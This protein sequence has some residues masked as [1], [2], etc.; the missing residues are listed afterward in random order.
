M[1][2]WLREARIEQGLTA[3]QVSK[4][5]GVSESYYS[6]IENGLRQTPM[7]ITLA[8]KIGSVLNLPLTYLANCEVGEPQRL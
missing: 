4:E 8:V 5:L 6:M 7:D 2:S 3:A 1:R